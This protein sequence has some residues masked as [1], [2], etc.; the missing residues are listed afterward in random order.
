MY[1]NKNVKLKDG[2]LET[3]VEYKGTDNFYRKVWF[4]IDG[5]LYIN[6]K[7]VTLR[8]FGG[9]REMAGYNREGWLLDR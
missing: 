1:T 7:W 5:W 2:W 6:T 9:F 3:W 8:D 4:K